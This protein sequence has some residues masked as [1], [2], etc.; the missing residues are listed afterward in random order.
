MKPE[1]WKDRDNK[2]FPYQVG[3]TSPPYDFDP[4]VTDFLRI[5]PEEV[6]A[7]GRVLHVPGYRHGLD[8]RAAN[9]HLLEEVGECMSACGADAVAQ[10]GTNWVHCSGT[11]A[12]E[13]AAFCRRMS[14]THELHFHMA[15]LCL[16]DSLR[17]LGAKRIAINAGYYWSDWRDGIVGFLKSAGFDVIYA[18]NFVD[19]GVYEEQGE[20][21]DRHWIFP[22]DVAVRS[23]T[24]MAEKAPDADAIVLTGLPNW[25][26]PDGLRD[27]TVT[28]TRDLEAATGK[29]IV[30]SDTALYWAV[31][32]SLGLK[33]NGSYGRLLDTLA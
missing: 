6:G 19:Q 30:A 10:V 29:T 32:N 21:N 18:G 13:I 26:R 14:E 5:A 15:G 24:R 25:R 1:R 20:V 28:L 3:F 8:Q 9:F 22:G 16:V 33:P 2:P 31:L 23:M 11:G 7:F 17:A 27:R 4:S 12:D